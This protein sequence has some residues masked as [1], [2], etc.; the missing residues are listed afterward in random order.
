MSEKK[1]VGRTVAIA[2]GI[3]CIVLAVG[4]M[5]AIL[6][7]TSIINGK[8]KTI[9]DLNSQV[10]SLTDVV[11]LAKS[12]VWVDSQTV[13]QGASAYTYWTFSPNYAG[14]VSVLLLDFGPTRTDSAIIEVIYSSHGVNYDSNKVW[15]RVGETAVFPVLPTSHLEVHVGNGY[16]F[17]GA[18]ETVTMTYYY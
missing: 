13:S 11:N 6:D 1:V 8:D 5:G 15:I 4:L 18:I 7:Y 14:Y 10:A 16:L 12:T 17:N 2:L 9:A 3:I